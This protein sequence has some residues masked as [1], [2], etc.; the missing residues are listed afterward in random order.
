MKEMN[1][2]RTG[3]PLRVLRFPALSLTSGGRGNVERS[4]ACPG[5]PCHEVLIGQSP[6]GRLVG[7]LGLFLTPLAA[8]GCNGPTEKAVIAEPVAPVR[9]VEVKADTL[10]SV[11]FVDVTKEAGVNFVHH[12]GAYGEKLLPETMGAGVA[13]LDYDNDG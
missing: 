1:Q 12:N 3:G 9:S 7:I 8:I 5:G 11:K 2:A 4:A 13:F 6:I 10:P